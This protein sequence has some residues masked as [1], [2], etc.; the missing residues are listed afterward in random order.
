MQQCFY[1]G[2]EEANTAAVLPAG[3]TFLTRQPEKEVVLKQDPMNKK[4]KKLQELSRDKDEINLLLI[5]PKKGKELQEIMTRK[6]QQ[7][8]CL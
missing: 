2:E 3:A 6:S 7:K 4:T 5:S 1:I 8:T